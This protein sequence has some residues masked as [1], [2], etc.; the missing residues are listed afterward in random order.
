[1]RLVAGTAFITQGIAG[2]LDGHP[3]KSEVL[4]V[5]A[6]GDGTLLI[7]GLWTPISGS[8][9][10]ILALRNI[11]AQDGNL[12]SNILLATIGAALALLGPGAW[13]VDARLFGW[14][15]IDIQRW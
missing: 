2:F 3:I 9:A 10:V 7:A 12:S 13:S 14:K 4:D 11:L 5:L 6:I 15:R 8:L 1:M